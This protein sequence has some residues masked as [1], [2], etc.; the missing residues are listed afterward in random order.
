M[1]T[2]LDKAIEIYGYTLFSTNNFFGKYVSENKK[3]PTKSEFLNYIF[4]YHFT[5]DKKT[6]PICVE[7]FVD[8]VF[9]DY[10]EIL[11]TIDPDIFA[12]RWDDSVYKDVRKIMEL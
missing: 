1:K 2:W 9:N 5:R 11:Q 4:M 3:Y 10:Q 8:E 6:L 7:Q 12:K